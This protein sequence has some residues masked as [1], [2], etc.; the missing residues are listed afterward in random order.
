[1]N[2]RTIILGLFFIAT[3]A[4]S[5]SCAGGGIQNREHNQQYIIYSPNAEPLSGGILGNPDCE[6][7][8]SGWFKRTDTNHDGFI[9]KTEFRADAQAQFKR[10][11]LDKAG[12][13]TSEVLDRYRA[14]YRPEIINDTP[15]T[16]KPADKHFTQEKVRSSGNKSPDS[17]HLLDPVMSADGNLDFR[18]T[19]DEFLAQSTRNFDVLDSSHDNKL[20][21][22][23]VLAICKKKCYF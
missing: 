16:E 17:E 10:M 1:M 2:Y 8:V 4:I 23:E 6:K 13:L 14:P 18:V 11:D 20:G 7:A 12:Y 9:D 19:L 5:A 15:Q 3:S 21:N 22:E